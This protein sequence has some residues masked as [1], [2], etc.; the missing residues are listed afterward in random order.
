MLYFAAPAEHFAIHLGPPNPSHMEDRTGCQ[1]APHRRYSTEV[2]HPC[3]FSAGGSA[4]ADLA[5]SRAFAVSLPTYWGPMY[6]R[7]G[8]WAC[9]GPVPHRSRGRLHESRGVNLLWRPSR[10]AR[11]LRLLA[12]R[13]MIAWV[14]MDLY[15][16]RWVRSKPAHEV[17]SPS[18]EK[19]VAAADLAP[20]R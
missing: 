6:G 5:R 7:M 17:Q 18:R 16:R 20:R 13:V 19:E 1:P 11:L 15:L 4:V 14:W 9:D 2:T 10:R 12:T 8:P 3:C